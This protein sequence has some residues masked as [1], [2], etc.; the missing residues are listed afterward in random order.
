M[1]RWIFPCLA[2]VIIAITNPFL[3]DYI[4]HITSDVYVNQLKDDANPL[5]VRNTSKILGLVYLVEAIMIFGLILFARKTK[6][7][8]SM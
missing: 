6:N 2:I 1:N 7:A 4:T 3:M 8:K 5:E